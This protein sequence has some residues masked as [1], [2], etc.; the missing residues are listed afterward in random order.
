MIETSPT[1]KLRF[2]F[3]KNWTAFLQLLDENRIQEAE[4]SLKKALNRSNLQG[5]RFLDIG[6]GSG[7]FSLAARR[8]GAEVHSFDYDLQ[9]VACTQSL[10]ERFFSED[11]KWTVEQGSVLVQPYLDSLGK[12]DIL[13]A[14]GVLHHTGNMLQAFEKVSRMVKPKGYI[15]MSI[16]NDQGWRTKLWILVKRKYNDV[17]LL[18][19]FIIGVCGLWI[20]KYRIGWGLVRYGNPFKFI[21]E[22][23]KKNRGMSAYHDLIDWVGG[24]P[25]EVA[26][27]EDVFHFFKAKGFSL[28]FLKTCGGGLGCNEYVFQKTTD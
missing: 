13:Y 22:Y 14:W 15:F 11:A 21:V 28:C 10:K 1:D 3:G 25:F 9:S 18:R 7:L 16:Y 12:F 4:V 8:L 19:P 5:L 2:G 27:P 26:K 23:G 17:K 24:Y 20:L 6:S